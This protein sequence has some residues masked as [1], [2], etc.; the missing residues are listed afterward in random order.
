[1][2]V[3]EDREQGGSAV[4]TAQKR[5]ARQRV[6]ARFTRW[7]YIL[8]GLTLLA[9][10]TRL[11]MLH[12]PTDAGTPVFDEKHY[13]PQAWQM[14]RGYSGPFIGGI[15]DNPG[16]GLVVHP[17]LAKQL[18][19][20]GMAVFGY[21]PLGWRLIMALLATATIVLIAMTARR[22]ARSDW[23]GLLAGVL[24]L[25]EGIL[26]VTGRSGMLD[27]A[28]T[29]FVVAAA[30]FLLRDQQEMKARFVRVF[31]QGR[32]Q[33]FPWGPRMGFRWWRFAAGV[34]LGL[35]LSVKWSGLYYMAFAGVTIVVLDYLRR[36][37]YRVAKALVGTLALDALPSFASVVL[38][39]AA[40]Y[41]LSF[42]AWFASDSSVYRHAI[43]ADQAE[44]F[45][46]SGLIQALPQS[47]QNFLFYHHSVLQFHTELTNS[48]GHIHPWESKPWSWLVSSR[49]LMYYNP[50]A[51]A[52]GLRHIVLL[53][54]TPAIWWPCVPVL[55]WG[56][57]C[58]VIRRDA[59]W[60]LPVVG[61]AAG[62][63]P[64][65][66][67][68]DRQ[69]YL[70]YAVN[71][72]PFLVIA[73]ALAMGQLSSWRLASPGEPAHQ[74]S[75]VTLWRRHTGRILAV[76]YV[77]FCVWNFLFFLPMYTGMPMTG[78]QWAFRMW[79]PSWA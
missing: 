52:E 64:W 21:T 56:L 42:R 18:Q 2:T 17:P 37:R 39:P 23:V 70:F 51:D 8:L 33:D 71:L 47:L 72:A 7:H 28:Q 50:D 35:S 24:A 67:A 57:W 12:R 3:A 11:P 54:G 43:E 36:R 1:M 44:G 34:A 74:Y 55:L 27:H 31:E 38:V 45:G 60:I 59:K 46:Q 76:A 58:L 61:F 15:E 49:S 73:L 14:L 26:F 25:S 77:V 78:A 62:F 22:V 53:V 4:G 66:F 20:L 75:A 63:V 13:V 32:M 69:M 79:L 30:Y 48:A 10:A 40:L 16:F 65:L 5:M 68:L 29:L 9:L 6:G 19:S 41:L